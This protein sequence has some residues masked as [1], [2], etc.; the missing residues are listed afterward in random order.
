[1]GTMDAPLRWHLRGTGVRRNGWKEDGMF[2]FEATDI[3]DVIVIT[4]QVFGDSRGYF[5]KTYKET[6]FEAAGIH[7]P[8]VQDRGSV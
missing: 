1:M 5:L 4:P 6:E 7:G 3:A 2:R 8:F